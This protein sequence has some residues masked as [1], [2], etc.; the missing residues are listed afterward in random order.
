MSED[1]IA[2]GNI[3]KLLKSHFPKKTFPAKDKK[4]KVDCLLQIVAGDTI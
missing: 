2:T 3:N 1:K 4:N